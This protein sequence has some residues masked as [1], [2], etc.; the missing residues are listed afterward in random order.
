MLRGFALLLLFQLAGEVL[1]HLLALPVP[2]PVVGMVLL[3]AALE[4]RPV[5]RERMKPASSGLLA[6]L[7]LLFVPAGVGIV[8]HAA[9][10]AAEWRGIAAALV[11][12]TAATILVTGWVATR[13]LPRAAAA[14]EGLPPA[15][16]AGS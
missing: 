6:F 9:R 13:L 4:L 2:G 10:L 3:L 12:S 5:E 1:A 15:T 7:S 11:L 14:P 8:Q 16:G